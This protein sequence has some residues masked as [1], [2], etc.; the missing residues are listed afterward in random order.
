[1]IHQINLYQ[2]SFK[3]KKSDLAYFWKFDNGDQNQIMNLQCT[4]FQTKRSNLIHPITLTQTLG[5]KKHA[6]STAETARRSLRKSLK[7]W[8]SKS[9]LEAN[10]IQNHNVVF[11]LAISWSY[12]NQ[13]QGLKLSEKRCKYSW[14]QLWTWNLGG[15]RKGEIWLFA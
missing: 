9:T 10:S 11:L 5:I 1:M 8:R 4:W 15:I 6:Q 14:K 7:K 2:G 13:S 12:S 3:H